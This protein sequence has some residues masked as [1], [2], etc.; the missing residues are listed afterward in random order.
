MLPQEL[1]AARQESGQ[2]NI[3]LFIKDLR[4]GMR[5]GNG[6]DLVFTVQRR[7]ENPNGAGSTIAARLESEVVRESHR[8]DQPVRS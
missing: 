1:T 7:R 3:S 5:R 6:G 4:E 2:G 8:V